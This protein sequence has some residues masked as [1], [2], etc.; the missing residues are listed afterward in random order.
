MLDKFDGTID[1]SNAT[2]NLHGRRLARGVKIDTRV[3]GK[4]SHLYTILSQATLKLSPLFNDWSDVLLSTPT[5]PGWM[6][7]AF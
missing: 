5:P 6:M 3:E 2:C 1:V 4:R 7:L